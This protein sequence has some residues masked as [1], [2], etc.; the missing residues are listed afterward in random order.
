MVAEWW[1]SVCMGGSVARQLVT[2]LML[3]HV[4]QTWRLCLEKQLIAVRPDLFYLIFWVSFFQLTSACRGAL[5]EIGEERISE[6]SSKALIVATL[7]PGCQTAEVILCP[8]VRR[9]QEWCN[10]AD[11]N[12]M[13]PW[14]SLKQ[15]FIPPFIW[16]ENKKWISVTHPSLVQSWPS[17]LSVFAVLIILSISINVV[18]GS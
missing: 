10:E 6:S 15:I 5:E 12:L 9:R 18:L 8:Y 17:V 1:E 16:E 13:L 11:F 14:L 4:E 2:T 7:C 3:P